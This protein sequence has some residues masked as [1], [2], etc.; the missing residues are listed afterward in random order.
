[1]TSLNTAKS[2]SVCPVFL[3]NHSDF[4]TAHSRIFNVTR[5]TAA[6]TVVVILLRIRWPRLAESAHATVRCPSVRPSARLSRLSPLRQCGRSPA[7]T[8]CHSPEGSTRC[9]GGVPMT[10]LAVSDAVNSAA[11]HLEWRIS[12]G[13]GT[14][15]ASCSTE[16][17]VRSTGDGR[18]T[19]RAGGGGG[20]NRAGILGAERRA[21]PR[22]LVRRGSECRDVEVSRQDR[23]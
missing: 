4:D 19:G 23:S 17:I 2:L 14:R 5:Q 13:P 9:P 16:P 12:D 11:G 22:G 20:V 3:P 6:P 18:T 7:Y 8:Q 1:M 21:D 10:L 15:A